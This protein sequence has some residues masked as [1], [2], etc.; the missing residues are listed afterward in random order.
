MTGPRFR[1]H[2]APAAVSGPARRR[3][4][5]DVGIVGLIAVIG[6]VAAAL[7]LSPVPLVGAERVVPRV[8]GI[9]LDSAR[10]ELTLLNYRVVVAEGQEHP[11]AR[12]GAVIWQDPPP[13]LALPA[14][15]TVTLTPSAG[16]MQVAIPDLSGVE[17]GQAALILAA[18][19]FRLGAI[20][21]VIDRQRDLG[22]VLATRPSAGSA[23]QPGEEVELI[24]NGASR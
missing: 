1:R 5:R 13:G 7:W 21:T 16:R 8:L 24:V 23:R 2:T 20:D 19:G 12:R 14:G 6:F 15:G 22:I 9:G 4:A 17:A 11:T 3:I 10:R 18:A